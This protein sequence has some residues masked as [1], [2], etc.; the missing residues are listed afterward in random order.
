MLTKTLAATAALSMLVAGGSALAAQKKSPTVAGPKAPVPYDQ[1]NAYL[2]ASPKARASKDWWAG[3][4]STGMTT[5]AAATA[6][7]TAS[8]PATSAPAP[9]MST[10]T[11]VNP[12]PTAAPPSLPVTPPTDAAPQ[13]GDP[14]APTP[15]AATPTEPK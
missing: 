7:A 11:S 8:D 2:K 1:L 4:A 6:P 10:D 3:S 15:P 13:P 9:S 5:D 12:A 14:T